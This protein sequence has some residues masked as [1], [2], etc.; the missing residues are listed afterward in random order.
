[1][2]DEEAYEKAGSIG[3]PLMFTEAR[4]AD[5]A[6][7]EASRGEVGELWFRGPHVSAGYWNNPSATAEA[8]DRK[9]WF[10]TGDMAV[11]DE[12]G[13]FY[14]AGRAKDMFISGGVNVYPAEIE[15]QL[16]QHPDLQD[17]AVVGA[18]D[19]TW[20]EVGVAFVVMGEEAAFNEEALASFLSGRL[21]R[22]KIPKRFIEIEGL[23]RTAYGKVVKGELVEQLKNIDE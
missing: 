16:L 11:Q 8:L 13:F 23:P 21:A 19:D 4:V 12:D 3:K 17:A 5:E 20:G 15:N 9:G 22:Y 7:Q 14:I 1:M 2:T 18:P 10:H 6:G